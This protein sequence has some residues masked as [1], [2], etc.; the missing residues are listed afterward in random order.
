MGHRHFHYLIALGSNMGDRSQ[1]LATACRLIAS[2]LGAVLAISESCETAPV[3]PCDGL[4]LNAALVCESQ[5]DP[6]STMAE[7]LRIEA[8]MGR[9]RGERWGNR[10]ID[11]DLLLGLDSDGSP[12]VHVSSRLSLPHPL[13]LERDFVLIPASAIAGHWLHPISGRPLSEAL[14]ELGQKGASAPLRSFP[15]A[16]DNA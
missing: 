9:V 1:Y 7:L 13:M 2:R 5:Q 16:E 3:G 10:I 8:E 15:S 4:F 11:L 12:I 14:A 6:E